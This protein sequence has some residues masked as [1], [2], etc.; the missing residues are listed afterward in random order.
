MLQLA[1]PPHKIYEMAVARPNGTTDKDLTITDGCS[2][3]NVSLV[4]TSNGQSLKRF[5]CS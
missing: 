5:F 2:S 4:I 1:E 3:K